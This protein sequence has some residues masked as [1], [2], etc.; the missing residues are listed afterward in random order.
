MTIASV[1]LI[2]DVISYTAYTKQLQYDPL[3]AALEQ[4]IRQLCVLQKDVLSY[5]HMKLVLVCA[6]L[7]CQRHMHKAHSGPGWAIQ[8]NCYFVAIT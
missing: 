5:S 1:M 6:A 7:S 4:Q 8:C 3:F 2:L